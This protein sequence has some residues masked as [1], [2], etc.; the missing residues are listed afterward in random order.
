MAVSKAGESSILPDYCRHRQDPAEFDFMR[1]DTW[2]LS[3]A[4][5]HLAPWLCSGWRL[6]AVTPLR[7]SAVP[8]PCQTALHL[9]CWGH[10]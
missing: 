2:Q 8:A 5:G 3:E 6:Q 9:D 7:Y 10:R 4:W 1:A